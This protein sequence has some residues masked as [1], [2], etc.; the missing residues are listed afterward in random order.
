MFD[1]FWVF[2]SLTLNLNN[3]IESYGYPLFVINIALYVLIMIS[4]LIYTE[5]IILNFW[6]VDKD[7]NNQIYSR[8]LEEYNEEKEDLFE[9]INNSKNTIKNI[10]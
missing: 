4:E 2:I 5:I 6:K 8:A 10:Q 3:D 9:L 7:I 1:M